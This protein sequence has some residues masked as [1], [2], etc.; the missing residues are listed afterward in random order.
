MPDYLPKGPRPDAVML[1]ARVSTR[2]WRAHNT[3]DHC[4]GAWVRSD[5]GPGGQAGDP[6]LGPWAGGAEGA[7]VRGCRGH[8]VCGTSARLPRQEPIAGG[9]SG[10]VYH[11]FSG[12]EIELFF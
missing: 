6:A 1:W 4:P 12:L 10:Y 5:R 11:F 7:G 2:I 8:G 3:Q 9:E